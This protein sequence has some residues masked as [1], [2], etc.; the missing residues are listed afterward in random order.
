[1]LIAE[2]LLLLVTD[3]D[4]GK[5]SGS[6]YEIE[7]GLAGA[8]LL[9]LTLMSKV[10]LTHEGD[11][12]KPGRLV[13]RDPSPTGDAVLDAALDVVGA[14]QGKK[15]SAVIRPLGK[16]LRQTLYERLAAGGVVRSEEG[17][18]LGI[19]PT[20]R[21]PAQDARHEAE[22]RRQLTE[23]LVQ[24][25]TPDARGAALI[26]LLH[27]LKSEHKVV[28]PRQHDLSKSELGKRA[29]A[30]AKG[31]WASDAVRKTV[32]EMNAAMMTAIMAATITSAGSSGSS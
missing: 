15:P 26:S 1:M 5:L 2:D 17:K 8:V 24:Q 27:A 28:D 23:A 19:F 32:D 18:V 10:D 9:E 13:V 4:T 7:A 16:K 22:V 30:I 6:A 11:D 14:H 21:W 12:G 29:E 3:D 25:T 20:H 31:D